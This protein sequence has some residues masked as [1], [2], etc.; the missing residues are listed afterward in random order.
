MTD[1]CASMLCLRTVLRCGSFGSGQR[2]EGHLTPGLHCPPALPP[3]LPPAPPGHHRGA[4][5]ALFLASSFPS[6]PPVSRNSDLCSSLSALLPGPCHSASPERECGW[7]MKA[8]PSG[9]G[10]SCHLHGQGTGG[11]DAV[12]QGQ[13]G[14]KRKEHGES[15]RFTFSLPVLLST[16]SPP[17]A[18]AS[19]L[20]GFRASPGLAVLRG[21]RL[22][23][24]HPPL[25][26]NAVNNGF[27]N[28]D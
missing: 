11:A 8:Q 15:P 10:A 19:L 25:L 5:A 20:G 9:P 7:R 3:S 24:R 4:L 13:L 1:F 22:P 16:L 23:P 14:D 28:W 21:G 26:F 6:P 18:K 2:V 12:C 27:I 17:C